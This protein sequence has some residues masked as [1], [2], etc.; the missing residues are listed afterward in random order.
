[1]R[2]SVPRIASFRPAAPLHYLSA[3]FGPSNCFFRASSAS[4]LFECGLRSLELLH[5]VYQRLYINQ[6]RA[7]SLE[8]CHSGLQRLYINRTKHLPFESLSPYQNF[9]L[10]PKHGGNKP[11][12]M[13]YV[14]YEGKSIVSNIRLSGIRIKRA[15]P[16]KCLCLQHEE[17][18]RWTHRVPCNHWAST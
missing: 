15:L 8:S 14:K 3:G 11:V 13:P 1:V 2:V 4:V 12:W 6:V 17:M 7:P 16:R 5:S 10:C 9:H 18:H